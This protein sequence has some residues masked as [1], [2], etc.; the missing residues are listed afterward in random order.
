MVT[1]AFASCVPVAPS[2]AA[3]V[4]ASTSALATV[5]PLQPSASDVA[6]S[7]QVGLKAEVPAVVPLGPLPPQPKPLSPDLHRLHQDVV[8]EVSPPNAELPPNLIRWIRNRAKTIHGIIAE[9]VVSE[10]GVERKVIVKKI[11]NDVIERMRTIGRDD[12]TARGINTEDVLAELGTY[13]RIARLS[14]RCR[15]LIQSHGV[16]KCQEF[17]YL[18]LEAAD[19]DLF[20]V[21]KASRSGMT[22]A[23][24][25]S[26]AWQLCVA[27]NFLHNAVKVCHNDINLENLLLKDGVLKLMDFGQ[28]TELNTLSTSGEEKIAELRRPRGKPYYIAP[29][30]YSGHYQGGRSD[31]FACGVVLFLLATGMPPWGSTRQSD[32]CWTWFCNKGCDIEALFRAAQA[33]PISRDGM[34]MIQLMLSPDPAERPTASQCLG[35]QWFAPLR[36]PTLAAPIAASSDFA[37]GA[38]N[39]ASLTEM[40]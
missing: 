39:V 11:K 6:S 23:R 21:V 27:V 4:A 31:I 22:E 12:H 19:A 16:F 25:M 35:K 29:E 3:D 36:R 33:Q 34:D 14:P 17:T 7:A 2:G 15:Y 38:E 40:S 28:A 18:V 32:P 37:H 20:D 30:E 1:S 26:F 8:W 24:V 10:E 13:C 9:H 5:D